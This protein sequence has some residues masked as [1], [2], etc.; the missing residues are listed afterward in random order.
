MTINQSDSITY[1][2]EQIGFDNAKYISAQA[3]GIAE[4]M[5]QFS[6]GKLYLEVGGKF[7][8]DAHASRVLPGFEPTAKLQIF[9]KLKRD[10]AI[11]FCINYDDIIGNRQLGSVASNYASKTLVMAKNI[12][13]KLNIKPKITINLCPQGE[14][15]ESVKKYRQQ[16]SE[17]GFDSFLRYRIADYPNNLKLITSQQGYGRDQYMQTKAKLVLVTGAASNSG[18]LSTCLGQI[19]HDHKRN[20]ISGYA[21]YETFPIWNLPLDHPVNLAYEAATADIGDYNMIDSYHQK[22]YGITSINYNRDVAAFELVKKIAQQFVPNDSYMHNYMSPTDMGINFAAAGIIDDTKC[23][24]AAIA[25]IKRRKN[26]YKQII[27]R[28]G[29]QIW[30]ERCDKLLE[31]AT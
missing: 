22:A 25:E 9:R 24:T 17:S 4:R 6:A 3:A 12:E 11:I 20:T 21:K 30:L 26:W 7:L 23:R 18:K 2:S 27:D 28:G 14:L 19:Y 1:P 15:D 16:V 29:K 10:M 31:K 13:K 8:F 5:Q